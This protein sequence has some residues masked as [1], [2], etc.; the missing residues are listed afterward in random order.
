MTAPALPPTYVIA[1]VALLYGGVPDGPARTWLQLY[2]LYWDK[3]NPPQLTIDD[4]IKLTGKS[5]S[6]LY[7]HLAYLG[8]SGWLPFSTATDG[9]LK[10]DFTAWLSKFSDTPLINSLTL[11]SNSSDS[12]SRELINNSESKKSDGKKRDPLLDNE[13]VR[14]YRRITHLTANAVQ[15]QQ[16]AQAVKD[17]PAWA[18]VVEHWM[19]HGWS[20]TNVTGMLSSYQ[21]GGRRACTLC[22]RPEPASPNGRKPLPD[23]RTGAIE[24]MKQEIADG[25]RH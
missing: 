1:P 15:R 19:G 11:D 21:K 13:A 12:D 18:E 14:E 16:L 20:P 3:S 22:N 7:G 17:I 10:F 4:L 24:R 2:G 9:T 6:T 8:N 25:K 23:K 5:R